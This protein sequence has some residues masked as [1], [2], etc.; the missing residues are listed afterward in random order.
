MTGAG[1]AAA[2]EGMW[3][4]NDFPTESFRAKYGFAPS[5]AFLEKVRESAVRFNNGGSGSFVSPEGLTLTN[6]HVGFDCIQKLSSAERDLVADGFVAATRADELPCPD[7]ELNVLDSIERVTARVRG[8]VPKGASDQQ[9]AEARRAATATIES[10]CQD[11]TGLRCNVITLYEGGE[12]DLYRYVRYTDVRLVWAPEGQFANFGGD[13]DNFEFPRFGLDV[14]IFRLWVDGKPLRPASWLPFDPDGPQAGEVTFLAGNPGSTGRL[15]PVAELEWLRDVAYPLT[16]ARLQ[17]LHG[18][19]TA[20][21]ARG[22]EEARIALDDLLS[23]ENALKAISGYQAGLLDEELMATKARRE[24]ELRRA[25]AADPKLAARIGDPWADFAGALATYRT[26]YARY[27]ALSSLTNGLLPGGA[28]E[29]VRLT[30]ERRKPNTERLAKYRETALPSLLQQLY[31]DAPIYPD[32]HAARLAGRLRELAYQFGP[33]HPLIVELLGDGTPEEVAAAAMAGTKLA[34]VT[35]RRRLI[36]GGHVAVAASDDPLIRMMRAVEPYDRALETLVREQ[37]EAI[38]DR[39]GEQI[40][41][42]YF[43]VHRDDTY[44]DA[45]FNLRLSYGRAIGYEAGGKDV[46]WHTTLGGLF[47]RAERFGGR[48]PFDVPPD[49]AAAKANVDLS[50]PLDFLSTNDIIGG[51]SGSPVIDRD[52]NFLGV[53]FDGNLWMLPNR[54]VYS[55]EK[56]RSI[57]VDVRAILEAL[58]KVYPADHV[59]K[60][61]LAAGAPPVERMDAAEGGR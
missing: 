29:I 6:H 7:L 5:E 30:E 41:E 44:P 18:E 2:D 17:R 13:P 8:A 11:A 19:L 37:V 58:T 53:V 48:A 46:P 35:V 40:A 26:V 45:T 55:E 59:A 61:L 54:F 50:T 60:E 51:N 15:A 32:Y 10:E 24:A 52:G 56:A 1:P 3:L 14:A 38:E 16:L 20:Y 23:I 33:T 57:S 42:A 22:E 34:D 4:L 43:A 25:V 36:E 21:S 27:Q 12:Y 39:A 49:L 47:E 9:A 28:M 31:S